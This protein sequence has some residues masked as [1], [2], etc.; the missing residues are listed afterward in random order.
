MSVASALFLVGALVALAGLGVY[1]WAVLGEEPVKP[2]A[3]YAGIT[4]GALM[5]LGIFSAVGW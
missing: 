5:V 3:K 1:L 4:G 2:L